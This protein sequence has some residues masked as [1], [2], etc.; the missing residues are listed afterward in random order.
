[1]D[2]LC[3]VGEKRVSEV[4]IRGQ[5]VVSGLGSIKRC[6][7]GLSAF[8]VEDFLIGYCDGSIHVQNQEG[9]ILR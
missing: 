6:G 2:V 3:L 5:T 9:H 8:G 1:M 4:T 7:Q